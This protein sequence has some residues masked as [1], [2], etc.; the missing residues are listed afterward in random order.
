MVNANCGLKHDMIIVSKDIFIEEEYSVE[1]TPLEEPSVEVTSSYIEL[2]DVTLIE[3]P[4]KNIPTSIVFPPNTPS[5]HSFTDPSRPT[6]FEHEI[7][8]I[9]APNLDQARDLD[10]TTGLEDWIE[11]LRFMP[12]LCVHA[13]HETSRPL[14]STLSDFGH[15]CNS[16]DWVPSFNKLKR[17]ITSILLMCFPWNILLAANDCNFFDNNS[18]LFDRLLRVL[19]RIDTNDNLAI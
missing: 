19:V 12:S 16:Y 15:V 3:F 14:C 6:F 10:V 4:S 17:A 5:S 11:D 8:M 7:C 1:E 2:I 9:Y 18:S 13:S